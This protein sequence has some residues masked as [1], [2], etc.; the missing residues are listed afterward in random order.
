M[1]FLLNFCWSPLSR[2]DKRYHL[3]VG[4]MY[5]ITC[6]FAYTVFIKSSVLHHFSCNYQI[7]MR[8]DFGKKRKERKKDN[9]LNMGNK[10]SQTFTLISHVR[11]I[12]ELKIDF[13]RGRQC[14]VL[15]RVIFNSWN[16]WLRCPE[17][18]SSTPFYSL[19]LAKGE[20]VNIL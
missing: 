20:K 2:N 5:G 18:N 6:K 9:K 4:T 14:T 17:K 8:L 10:L 13:S 12:V 11:R 1:W 7:E 19:S 3:T 16:Q 15:N